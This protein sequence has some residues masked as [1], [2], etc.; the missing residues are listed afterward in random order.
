MLRFEFSFL[1]RSFPD[2][3]HSP[4]PKNFCLSVYFFSFGNA[5]TRFGTSDRFGCNKC[6]QWYLRFDA[7][8]LLEVLRNKRLMFVGDSIQRGMFDS[9][10]CLVQS[11]IPD[12]KKSLQR[13][14]PRKIFTA[15]VLPICSA[16]TNQ[17]YCKNHQWEI[18]NFLLSGV[19][20]IHRV[21]LGSVHSWV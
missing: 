21:L 9:M 17:N 18:N 7:L 1:C 20:C 5:R 8:K 15:K 10:V 6:L 12:G 14:P 4:V 16:H 11:V 13:I 2:L 19:Q 3:F